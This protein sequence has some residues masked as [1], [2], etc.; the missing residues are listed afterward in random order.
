MKRNLKDFLF[1]KIFFIYKAEKSSVC[2]KKSKIAHNFLVTKVT[3]DLNFEKP[4]K[5]AC[6]TLWY[7]FWN[8]QKIFFSYF[9]SPF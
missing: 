1:K 7:L 3:S 5:N 6:V 2:E 8:P 4:L 9:L